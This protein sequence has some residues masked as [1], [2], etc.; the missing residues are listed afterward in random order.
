M[1]PNA[2]QC[3]IVFPSEKWHKS[4][5]KV[6]LLT[7]CLA[8][9]FSMEE[10]VE[11]KWVRVER[12][13][14]Y[15]E[16][17]SRKHG[18]K[19]DRYYVLRYIVDGVKRQE[20]LGWASE[21]VTL[22]KA[23]IELGRLKEANRL[24]EGPRTLAER[25]E[26]FK[27]KKDQEEIARMLKIRN[28]MTFAEFWDA[29][30]WP[31]QGHKADGSLVAENALFSKWIAPVLKDKVFSQICAS[32]IERIK[33]SMTRAKKATSSIKYAMAVISQ[34]WTL[35]LR[36]NFVVE[37]CPVKQIILQKKD[38]KRQRFLNKK[39]SLQL[40]NELKKHSLMAHNMALLAIDCGLRFGEISGLKW[41]DCNFS[42][43]VMLIRD[44]KSTVNRYAFMTDRV[45]NMFDQYEK[46]ENGLIFSDKNGNRVA[47]ISNTF[48]RIANE[49]FNIG[50]KD[51]RLKV[52]FHTLRHTFASRLVQNGVSLF[53]V[54]ELLGHS[55]FSMT[56]RYSHLSPEGLQKVVKI[57][58]RDI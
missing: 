13:I 52:C 35:A 33:I 9:E 23:R 26:L 38:N 17:P 48:R 54:K 45:R 15:R 36:D 43:G 50:V 28:S 29:H 37:K 14:R 32:D 39:E 58:N 4:G 41:N 57:L 22:E 16:H 21:G 6:L 27:I 44:P 42:S 3:E 31:A 51:S 24:G 8:G 34:V 7:K 30:Y 25:R 20:A 2:S 53:E 1:F 18:I 12:G 47:R 40:L 49:M 19:P 46:K 11:R 5:T 56:Q 10:N 55:D